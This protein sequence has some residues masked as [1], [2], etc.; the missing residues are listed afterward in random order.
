MDRGPRRGVRSRKEART[1]K[2]EKNRQAR[3][4]LIL[5]H[6]GIVETQARRLHQSSF[7]HIP[8]EDLQQDGQIGLIQGID[9]YDPAQSKGLPLTVWLRFKIRGAV[10]DRHRRRHYRNET[11]DQ[12]DTDERVDGPTHSDLVAKADRV[13]ILRQVLNLLAPRE[14]LA[15]QTYLSGITLREAAAKLGITESAT[16]LLRQRARTQAA[17]LLGAAGITSQGAV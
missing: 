12:L 13:R 6:Q 10:I 15:L 5:E 16:C 8:L 14:R 2:E 1:G 4:A 7:S 11:S 9:S 3:E 17:V